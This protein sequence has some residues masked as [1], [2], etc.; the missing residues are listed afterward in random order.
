MAIRLNQVGNKAAR[1]AI[2]VANKET[3]ATLALGAPAIFQLSATADDPG[4]AM[5][6]VNPSTAAAALYQLCAGVLTSAIPVNQFGEAIVFGYAPSTLV[7]LNTRATSTDTWASVQSVASALLLVPDFT[8]NVW[9]TLANVAA[10]SSPQVILLDTIASIAS[11]SSI[12]GGT[13]DTRVVSTGLKR[14]FVRM[15]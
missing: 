13:G 10:Q 9:Q 6:V 1:V 7:K 14:A 11:A 4:D 2:T 15:L 5:D 8:N 12:G 3:S